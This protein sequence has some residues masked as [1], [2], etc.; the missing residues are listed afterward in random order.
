MQNHGNKLINLETFVN[1]KLKVTKSSAVPDLISFLESK[2]KKEFEPKCKQ[3]LEYLKNDS[4]LPMAEL[5]V[6][7]SG[8]KQLSRKYEND[9]DTFLWVT[10]P[11]GFFYGTWDAAYA[12][13]Y[14]AVKNG[15]K[16]YTS[17][18]IKGFKEL[19]FDNK[20]ISESGGIYIITEN[21]EL[22]KQINYLMQ[23][24]EPPK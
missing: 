17:S 16:N 1:E 8:F 3:L 4:N 6:R 12:I 2:T 9:T 11:D 10:Y 20:E 23:K 5:E 19:V 24:A 18:V 15:V 14:S 7:E 13:T 22:M 21:K